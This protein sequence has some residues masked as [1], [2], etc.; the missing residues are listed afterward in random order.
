L[1]NRNKVLRDKKRIRK[2]TPE[3]GSKNLNPF[4]GGS[5]IQDALS[6][7]V[8]TDTPTSQLRSFIGEG[9]FKAFDTSVNN[10]ADDRCKECKHN[11]GNGIGIQ[12]KHLF[13][14]GKNDRKNR[15]YNSDNAEGDHFPF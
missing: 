2:K 14:P 10:E 15:K 12:D 6:S 8:N 7:F 13:H 5:K 3:K 4:S 9:V 1:S 11:Q